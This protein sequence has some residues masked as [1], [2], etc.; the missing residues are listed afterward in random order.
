MLTPHKSHGCT[1]TKGTGDR[2]PFSSRWGRRPGRTASGR[3]TRE[4]HRLLFCGW[5]GAQ[6]LPGPGSRT[7]TPSRRLTPF[8]RGSFRRSN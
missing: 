1:L 8:L 4:E 2:G 6:P 3:A 5:A 7:Q